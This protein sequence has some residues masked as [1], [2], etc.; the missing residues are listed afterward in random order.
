M[1]DKATNTIKLEL[2]LINK[3]T[4]TLAK[5]EGFRLMLK[6]RGS[7]HCGDEQKKGGCLATCA[8]FYLSLWTENRNGTVKSSGICSSPLRKISWKYHQYTELEH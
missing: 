8:S 6:V 4:E 5:T 2:K 3:M 1:Q 7:T